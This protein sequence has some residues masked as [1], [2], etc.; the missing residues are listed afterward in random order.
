MILALKIL[1]LGLVEG[2]Q[3]NSKVL[4]REVQVSCMYCSVFTLISNGSMNTENG[5]K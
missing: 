3:V 4:N 1:I 2:L 5:E